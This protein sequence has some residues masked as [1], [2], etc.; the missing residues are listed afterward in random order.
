MAVEG[1]RE[2]NKVENCKLFYLRIRISL[3]SSRRGLLELAQRNFESFL[4]KLS[5]GT[6]CAW[7]L[8]KVARAAPS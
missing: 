8:R 4:I 5:L 6:S 2:R 7:K 1:G 3:E